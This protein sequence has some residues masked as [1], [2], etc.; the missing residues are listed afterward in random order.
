[1]LNPWLSFSFQAVRLGLETHTAVLDQMMRIEGAGISDP[2]A[3]GSFDTTMP[4]PPAEDRVAAEAP[5]SPVE[6][7]GASQE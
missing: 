3:V 2:K 1:M 6:A 7:R 5:T 4:A